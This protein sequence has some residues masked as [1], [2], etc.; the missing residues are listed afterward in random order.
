LLHITTFHLYQS[1][2]YFI[3]GRTTNETQMLRIYDVLEFACLITIIGFL[4]H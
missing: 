4:G 1:M 3:L 2:F